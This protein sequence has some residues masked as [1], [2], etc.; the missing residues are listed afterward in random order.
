MERGA[1]SEELRDGGEE[2]ER[3]GGVGGKGKEA[4]VTVPRMP[5]GDAPNRRGRRARERRNPREEDVTGKGRRQ[6]RQRGACGGRRGE[7]AEG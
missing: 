2:E 3:E 6:G 1:G 4:T 5:E 7:G